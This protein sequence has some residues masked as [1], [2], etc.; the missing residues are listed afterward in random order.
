MGSEMCIRDSC[1]AIQEGRD[2]LVTGEEG[3][4]AQELVAA[5][6]LSGCTGKKV[7]LPVDRAE[8]DELM[9]SLQLA[10]RL[11]DICDVS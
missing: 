2:P 4:R 6:T 5:I 1:K 9:E 7:E 11:P 3:A 10:G 8:Y